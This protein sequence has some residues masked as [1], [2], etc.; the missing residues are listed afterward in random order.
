MKTIEY[1]TKNPKV[2]IVYSIEDSNEPFEI[3]KTS[4]LVRALSYSIRTTIGKPATLLRKTGT[5]DMN[6][7]G[8]AINAPI[9]TYGPGDS[10]LDHTKDEHIKINDYIKSI[11]E[12]IMDYGLLLDRK[13]LIKLFGYFTLL[14]VI[15]NWSVVPLY[16]SNN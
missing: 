9:V 13:E 16:K 8:R 12:L 10:H 14:L 2:K 11:L 15:F 5:G 3:N 1:S 6:I 7:L 4:P